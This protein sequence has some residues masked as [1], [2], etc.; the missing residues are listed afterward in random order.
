MKKLIV[1]AVLL[2]AACG[3]TASDA[4]TDVL[5]SLVPAFEDIDPAQPIAVFDGHTI[6]ARDFVYAFRNQLIEQEWMLQMWLEFSPEDIV[7]YW[8]EINEETGLTTLQ[9]FRGNILEQVLQQ[10]TIRVLAQEAGVSYDVDH[11]NE[12]MGSLREQIEDLYEAGEEGTE[13][14][15]EHFGITVEDFEHVQRNVS[16][17]PAFL[18]HLEQ[19]IQVALIELSDYTGDVGDVENDF[20]A[21]IVQILAEQNLQARAVHVL[22]STEGLVT[23]EEIDEAYQQAQDILSR[24]N[25]GENPRALAPIYSADPGSPDGFYEFPRG[26][27]VPEF[28]EWAFNAQPGDTG[29]VE[30]Q[31]GFHVMYSEGQDTPDGISVSNLVQFALPE[32]ISIALLLEMLDETD[33]EWEVDYAFLETVG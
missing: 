7:Q 11:F 19:D 24:I 30:T 32:D 6:P 3:A 8:Q 5:V 33:I 16:F 26:M 21:R 23:A 2:L 12:V 18:N 29:I 1:L 27:M 25:A 15:V 20:H 28:E 4:S 22:I 14:F 10:S 9:S 13:I 17:I 31:F